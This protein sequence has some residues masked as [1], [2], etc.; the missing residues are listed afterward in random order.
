[1]RN[2][3]RSAADPGRIARGSGDSDRGHPIRSRRSGAHPEGKI[4]MC[5]RGPVPAAFLSGS[6]GGP[7]GGLPDCPPGL[8]LAPRQA[9]GTWPAR[10]AGRRA[11]EQR[12]GGAC[13]TRNRPRRVAVP[14]IFFFLYYPRLQ[15]PPP[16]PPACRARSPA[17]A[18]L[19]AGFGRIVDG[20][21][22]PRRGRDASR[23]TPGR[24]ARDARRPQPRAPRGTLPFHER[25]RWR[26]LASR[27]VFLFC[28]P[29]SDGAVGMRGWSA[30][31]GKTRTRKIQRCLDSGGLCVCYRLRMSIASKS[32]VGLVYGAACSTSSFSSH[33]PTAP[34]WIG[35]TTCKISAASPELSF[36]VEL[37][38]EPARRYSGPALWN[39]RKGTKM[40][41]E[42]RRVV[43]P[44]VPTGRWMPRYI[45][46]LPIQL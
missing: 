15:A 40:T 3:M 18:A 14:A 44:G 33:P 7:R 9:A 12:G 6:G 19:P 13:E 41:R 36:S 39:K 32:N 37:S 8:A 5:A 10:A 21:P 30:A 42:K 17:S 38:W 2:G 20:W 24:A 4:I 27:I 26:P 35:R 45:H 22:A 25:G 46:P 1:M 31:W 43:G 28:S 29:N 11:A 23:N 34:E 16:A